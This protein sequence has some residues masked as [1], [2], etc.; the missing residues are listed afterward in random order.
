MIQPDFPQLEYTR[1]AIQVLS[2]RKIPVEWVVRTIVSPALRMPDPNDPRIERF[3][4][5]IPEQDNRVLRVAANT[6]AVPWRVVS[7]FFDRK[8]RGKL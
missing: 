6:H 7:V 1:H 8:M 4:R 5:R 3:F 2:E